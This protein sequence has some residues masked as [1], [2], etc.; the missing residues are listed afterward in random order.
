MPT[1]ADAFAHE[2]RIAFVQRSLRPGSVIYLTVRF[3]QG[4]RSKYLVVAKV[5]DD[6]TTFIINTRI[7]DF[8]LARPELSICQVAID[9]A[10]HSFLDHD[11]F[12]ACHESWS[13]RTDEVLKELTADVS[14]IHG[15][16]S[17]TTA[18]HVIA[19][20]K[21]SPMLTLAQQVAISCSIETAY[22]DSAG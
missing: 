14:R 15:H 11:S 8:L 20:V 22:A 3:P 13:F 16:L 19:A 18:E 21:R 9:S 4:E 7:N 17:K 5:D 6:C 2:H 1:L 10:S 12:I